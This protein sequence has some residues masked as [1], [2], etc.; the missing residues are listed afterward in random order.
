MHTLKQIS[1]NAPSVV[2]ESLHRLTAQR[3]LA[4]CADLRPGRL[5]TPTAAAKHTL[6][7]LAR[8]WFALAREIATHD[9]HLARLTTETS[10]TLGAGFGVG[11]NIVAELLIVFGDH[12]ERIRSEA[13]FAKLCGAG[14]IPVSSGRTTG[15]HRLDRVVTARPTP[16]SNGRSSSA[17]TTSQPSTPLRAVRRTTGPN[18]RS[19]GASDVSSRARSTS[20]S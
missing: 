13:H 15:R 6:R 14:P 1:V 20:A 5:D 18:V 7:A 16:P 3:L 2:R 11:V 8:C 12:P 4:R 19:S 9:R 10:P 17:G